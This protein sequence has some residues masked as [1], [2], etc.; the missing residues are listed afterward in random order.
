MVFA[1]AR[2]G[3]PVRIVL[4]DR[5]CEANR[6]ASTASPEPIGFTKGAP[7]LIQ[8]QPGHRLRSRPIPRLHSLITRPLTARPSRHRLVDQPVA[9]QTGG[10]E[11]G[12]SVSGQRQ[13]WRTAHGLLAPLGSHPTVTALS[14]RAAAMRPSRHC[15]RLL[16]PRPRACPGQTLGQRHAAWPRAPAP[17][18][19][20]RGPRDSESVKHSYNQ[21]GVMKRR[22]ILT[23]GLGAIVVGGLLL[24]GCGSGGDRPSRRRVPG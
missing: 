17:V 23:G 3:F 15:Q 8:S 7:M 24:T 19:Q 5:R 9:W 4:T 22:R 18:S 2:Y 1:I 14:E 13:T 12:W 10:T 20:G 11:T 6:V 16:C 21:E